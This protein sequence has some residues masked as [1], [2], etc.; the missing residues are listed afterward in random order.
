M[1]Q[2]ELGSGSVAI[3]QWEC[4]SGNAQCKCGNGSGALSIMFC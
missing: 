1:S 4:G 3:G 2:W